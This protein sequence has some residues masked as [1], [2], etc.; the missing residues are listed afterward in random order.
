MTMIQYLSDTGLFPGTATDISMIAAKLG[1]QGAL[2]DIQTNHPNDVVSMLLF[3]RPCY[4]GEPTEAGS[5]SAPQYNL[6]RDYAGMINALWFPPNSGSADV[7]PWDANGVQTPRAHGDYNGNT[8]TSYGFMLAYNQ[9]SSQPSLRTAGSG[10]SGFGGFGRK[11]AQRLVILE[12][13]GMANVATQQLFSNF[14]AYNSYYDLTPGSLRP[15]GNAPGQDAINVATRI[16]ALT[17][18]NSNGPGF[19]LPNK[20]VVL[21]CIG[22]G[23]VFEPT[24]QGGEP[25]AAMSFLQQLSQIGGTGFPASVTATGDPNYY[26]LCVGTLSQR[27]QKLRTAFSK[28]MDDGIS[29]VMVK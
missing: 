14:G 2:T 26:K 5:F 15:S 12:T 3:S 27:Q 19:A 6:S 11:G 21:H 1:I 20:P 18:D 22:F 17:T 24:A 8:A 10:G 25:A 16:C 23:A 4:L 28:I 29:V 7:R 9:F 13:D